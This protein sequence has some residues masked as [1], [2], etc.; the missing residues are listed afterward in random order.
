M[1]ILDEIVAHKQ[2]EVAGRKIH[3]PVDL[4]E[5]GLYFESETFSLKKHIAGGDESGIIAE[6]KRKSPSKGLINEFAELKQITTGYVQAGASALS[7]LTD[8]KFFGGSYNDLATAR[9]ANSCPIL[10][11]DFIIDEYQIIGAK[12]IGSDAI[13]LIAAILDKKK[14]KQLAKFAHS[15]NLEVLLEIHN[16]K[17]LSVLNEYIDL[18]GVNNRNLQDFS[19]DVNTSIQ[20][21]AL[22]PDD[23]LKISESGI[24]SPNMIIKLKK[25]GFKGFLIGESFMKTNNPAKACRK[26]VHELNL[27][28]QI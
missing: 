17:E 12:S 21:S 27:K 23:F 7:I 24:S 11:K 10:R 20:L 16:K 22:I 18:V 4:L 3:Y 1:N 25:H 15:L 8:S 5:Q 6:F 19:V 13:L 28:R 14:I 9:Q 26:F 2:K